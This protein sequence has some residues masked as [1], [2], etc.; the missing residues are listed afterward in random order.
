MTMTD[1]AEQLARRARRVIGKDPSGFERALSQLEKAGPAGERLAGRVEPGVERLRE[2]VE[3][4]VERMR[5]A[6]ERAGSTLEDALED[7]RVQ[8]WGPRVVFALGGLVVGFLLGWMAARR[9][10]ITVEMNEGIAQA[11]REGR[12]EGAIPPTRSERSRERAGAREG[13]DGQRD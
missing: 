11:P 3:P 10:S 7:E 8:A 5:D 2:A 1:T 13:G 12:H 6:V 4:G 9:G